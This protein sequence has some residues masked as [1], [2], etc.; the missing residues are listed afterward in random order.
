MSSGAKSLDLS[1]HSLP[2]E[3]PLGLVLTYS[4]GE[5]SKTQQSMTNA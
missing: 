2:D 4:L 3:F 1:K 5:T